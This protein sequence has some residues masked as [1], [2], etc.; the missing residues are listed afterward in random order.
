LSETNRIQEAVNVL[1]LY[2]SEVRSGGTL[3]SLLKYAEILEKIDLNKA[4]QVYSDILN[5][6][7]RHFAM[8]NNIAMVY[9]NLGRFEESVKYAE[10][11]YKKAET[12]NAV[13]NTYGLTLLAVGNNVEAEKYLKQAFLGNQNNENYKVHYA[14]SLLSNSK[15][16]KSK[17]LFI[18]VNKGELNPYSLIIY[19]KLSTALN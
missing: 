12:N 18:A 2:H 9:L 15:T 11:A 1:E 16:E 13:Q 5:K 14:Q 4:L 17:A 6:S 19:N 7:N 3:N 10:E 8:L